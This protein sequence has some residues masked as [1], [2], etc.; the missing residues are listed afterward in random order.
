MVNE[1]NAKKDSSKLSNTVED[2]GDENSEE[3]DDENDFMK[4]VI[5]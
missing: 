2:Y 4:S 5:K 3:E 1:E